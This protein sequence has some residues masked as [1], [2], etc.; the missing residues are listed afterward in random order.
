VLGESFRFYV[1]KFGR[2][3]K[4]YGAIGGVTILLFFFYLDAL[5]LL[6]GAE[7]NSQV[8]RTMKERTME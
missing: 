5:V 6:I 8:D 4:T 2:Y 7:I 1:D 3:Q